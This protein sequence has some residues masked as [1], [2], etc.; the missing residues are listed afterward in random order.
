[1]QAYEKLGVFYLGRL[2]DP[3]SG[4]TKGEPVLYDARDLTTHAVCV[5]MT[6]SGK[7]GLCVS[8]I[9]EAAIDGIPV[10]AIDPKGDLGNLLLAFPGLAPG[11]FEPWVDEGEAARKGKTR[12]EY[13][14]AAAAA[15]REGL[16]AW[17]QDG[18]RIAAFSEAADRAIY[19]PGSNAGLPLSVLR[20]LAAPAAALASNAE[21]LTDRAGAT[22]SGLL[23]LVGIEADPIRGRE[24]ILLSH[25]LHRAWSEGRSLGLGALI[26]EVQAPPFAKVGVLDLESFFPSKER[27]LLALALNNLLASPGF[28]AWMEGEPLDIQRLLWTPKGKPRISILSIAHLSDPER[29]FF[30][31]TLLGELLAWVRT[32]PGTSSLRAILYMDEVFGF[33]PP[34]ANPPSKTPML[35]LLKQARA[36]G[37]GCVLATQNPVDLDYKG[38]SNAG[39]WFLGRLQTERDK[40]KV[41]DGLA[42]AAPGGSLD[43]AAIDRAL[44]GLR[45]RVFLMHNVHEDHPVLFQSRWALSYLRGPLSQPEI[46][47]L[48]RGRKAGGA[49]T[50][51]PASPRGSFEG[52][53]GEAA[54]GAPGA[55]TRTVLPP[56]INEHFL[57]VASPVGEGEKLLYRPALLGAAKMHF[58]SVREKIDAWREV[59]RLAL[60]EEKAADPW[61]SSSAV[62]IREGDLASEPDPRGAFAPLPAEAST[63]KSYPRW[64]KELQGHLY[65]SEALI[66]RA[67]PAVGATSAPGENEGDFRVRAAQLARE[68]RDAEVEKLRARYAPKLAQLAERI[69]AA[70]E[71]VARE[72][73]QYK[74]R[75]VESAVSI[76]A[77]LLGAMFGR[78]RVSA[79]SLGRATT[80]ARGIGR[81]AREREDIARAEESAGVLKEKLA[82][83]EAEFEAEAAALQGAIDPASLAIEEKRIAP[84]KADIAVSSVKLVWTPWKVRADGSVGAAFDAPRSP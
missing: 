65:R 10:I 43:R 82:A 26:R 17:D 16:A 8:L 78:R 21:A 55:G 56:E 52:P 6:G 53:A 14:A 63:A 32:Q 13:A 73:A 58:V 4:E 20:S 37:L 41:L 25:I 22:V 64:T 38:L 46:E 74:S 12:A 18:A 42:S 31:T 84:R 23:A 3:G 75:Q 77:T 39:T 5:G 48:M 67:C 24:H 1:M 70:E 60:F 62:S 11:D 2:V 71:R 76:G 28:G 83:L 66:L 61:A 51:E 36:F 49:E 27:F 81:A 29:M 45:S 44:S 9:E 59:A 15:W 57:H 34:V 54:T 68:K 47:R 30:V 79:T 40:E 35:T 19:T 33:F 50:P 69:R 72:A 80:A 7:T